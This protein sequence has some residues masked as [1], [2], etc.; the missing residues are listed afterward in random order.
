LHARDADGSDGGS[1]KRGKQNAAQRVAD[2][3]TVAALKGFG[4]EL[5]VGVGGGFLVANEAVREL[6]TSKFGD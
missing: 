3:V 6:E 4:Y 1:L 2:G 5:R